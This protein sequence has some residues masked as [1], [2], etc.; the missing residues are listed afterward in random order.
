MAKL[1]KDAERI[2]NVL[3]VFIKSYSIDE[4]SAIRTGQTYTPEL[5]DK[6]VHMILLLA[7]SLFSEHPKVNA[8]PTYND[9][10]NTYIFRMSLCTYLLALEWGVLGGSQSV[11]I[12]RLRNDIVDMHFATYATYF[13]GLL[14]SDSK[15]KRIYRA[16]RDF[17]TSTFS[18]LVHDGKKIKTIRR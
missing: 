10:P 16:A 17:L 7:G 4:R 5:K 9:L 6:I 13:D 12:E 15:P 11:K 1:T 18:G 14:S 8:L 3:D 2:K